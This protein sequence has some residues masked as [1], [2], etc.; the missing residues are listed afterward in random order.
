M[1]IKRFDEFVRD[2]QPERKAMIHRAERAV[3]ENKN[4]LED[5]ALVLEADLAVFRGELELYHNWLMEQFNE[6]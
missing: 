4:R 2:T 6:Q 3:K 1:R 5:V